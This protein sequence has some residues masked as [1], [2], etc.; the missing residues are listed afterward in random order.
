MSPPTR[1]QPSMPA[2]LGADGPERR[3]EPLSVA[4]EYEMQ[5]SWRLDE[6]S[7]SSQ[8]AAHVLLRDTLT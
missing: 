6:D 1:S 5:R 8:L 4:E 2:A 3:S 7:K